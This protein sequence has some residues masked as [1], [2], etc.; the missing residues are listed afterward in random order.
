MTEGNLTGIK[1]SKG[2]SIFYGDK[3]QSKFGDEGIVK[4]GKILITSDYWGLE[5]YAYCPHITFKDNSGSIPVTE[6]F[7]KIKK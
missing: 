6:E 3:V 4:Y 7:T 5:Y 1:D 2:E